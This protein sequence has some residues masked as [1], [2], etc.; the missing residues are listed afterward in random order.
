MDRG[1]DARGGGGLSRQRKDFNQTPALFEAAKT[2]NLDQLKQLLEGRPHYI[3]YSN[4]LSSNHTV[5]HVACLNGQY[6]TV[7]WLVAQSQLFPNM[8]DKEGRTALHMCCEK[9]DLTMVRLLLVALP[10][11]INL[12][13]ATSNYTPL[14]T[15][16]KKGD[17]DLVRELLQFQGTPDNQHG[18]VDVNKGITS[19]P[20]SNACDSGK[21]KVFQL[22][23][24]DPRID[25][26]GRYSSSFTVLHRIRREQIHSPLLRVLLERPGLDVNSRAEKNGFTP[27]LTAVKSGNLE[28]VELLLNDPR[29]DRNTRDNKDR[30]IT[31]IANRKTKKLLKSFNINIPPVVRQEELSSDDELDLENNWDRIF[32]RQQLEAS[33]RPPEIQPTLLSRSPQAIEA[34]EE[35]EFFRTPEG[36]I[37]ITPIPKP[38]KVTA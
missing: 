11:T 28:A 10:S 26:N 20:L 9:G 14:M 33:S 12:R 8:S 4:Q 15:V 7:R 5:L 22:L 29:V 23:L 31:Q 27:L 3:N 13:L 32:P 16:C 37:I 17:E 25:I 35:E 19:S 6:E 38:A 21:P 18:R 24:E 34:E 36:K 30:S 2:G 1:G